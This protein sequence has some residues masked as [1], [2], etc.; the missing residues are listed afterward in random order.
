MWL[1]FEV[2]T[3]IIAEFMPEQFMDLASVELSRTDRLLMRI[4]TYARNA[5]NMSNRHVIVV[6]D[7]PTPTELLCGAWPEMRGVPRPVRGRGGAWGNES[8]RP[9]TLQT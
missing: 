8:S 9:R 1:D 7:L 5:L 2:D 6:P 4:V 3:S